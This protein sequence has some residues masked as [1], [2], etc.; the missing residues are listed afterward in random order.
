[1]FINTKVNKKYPIGVL[2]SNRNI[3]LKKAIK[4]ATNMLDKGPA[5]AV[6]AVP[7]SLFSKLYSFTGTGLLQP[8]L[9]RTIA[10]A[11]SG[12]ICF[13]GFNVNLPSIFAVGSPSLYAANPCAYSCIVDAIKIDGIAKSIQYSVSVSNVNIIYNYISYFV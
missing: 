3:I 6:I 9:K 10:N 2:K 1:M 7:S 5:K 8:N 4:I 13:K 12:S 11:P